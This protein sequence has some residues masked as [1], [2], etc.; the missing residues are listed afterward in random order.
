MKNSFSIM[1]RLRDIYIYLQTYLPLKINQ[2][3]EREKTFYQLHFNTI[4]HNICLT[5]KKQD[6]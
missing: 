6:Y 1:P 4:V 3:S 5:E 2:T